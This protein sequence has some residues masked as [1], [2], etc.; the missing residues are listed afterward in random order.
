MMFTLAGRGQAM[1]QPDPFGQV[2][3]LL[4]K[5]VSFF[6][7]NYPAMPLIRSGGL[8]YILLESGITFSLPAHPIITQQ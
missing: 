4:I 2:V 3:A 1:H 6:G 8:C 7:A 5:A